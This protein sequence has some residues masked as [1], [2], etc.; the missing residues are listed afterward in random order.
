MSKTIMTVDDALTM[1]QM[2]SLTLRGSG[3]TVMEAVDGAD[4]FETLQDKQVD[5]VI[6]D[7]NMPRMNGIELVT[8]LR[9]L[10][11]F[12]STPILILT[13]ESAA[14]MKEK[15]KTAGAT[16]WIVKPFQQQQLLTVVEK[17][18]QRFGNN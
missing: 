9:T 17:V 8:K 18:F 1:R 16:G 5:L 11:Q 13:T 14:D 15:G 12:K 4:A 2:I 10:P 6:T 3:Y 7:I